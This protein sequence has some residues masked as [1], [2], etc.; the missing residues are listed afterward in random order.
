MVKPQPAGTVAK[1]TSVS[2]EVF[3]KYHKKEEFKAKVVPK[4]DDV[5]QRIK[6]RLMMAFMFK[7]LGTEEL[8][9]VID[10]MEEKRFAAGQTVITEGEP[11]AVLFVVDEGQLDCHKTINPG[12]AQPTFLKTYQPGEAFGELALL[13]N[14]PR[15][16][17]I[18]A[19]TASTLWQLDRD[20]F[21]HI[22]KDAAQNKRDRYEDFLSSVPILQSIDHYERSKIADAIKEQTYQ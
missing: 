13:Y 17:T 10:A 14:A 7:A 5:K 1:R 19:K 2:A 20:T 4:T 16:A 21:N 12:D 18:T 6:E 3:G 9:I 15:A 8:T 22:V 11:G